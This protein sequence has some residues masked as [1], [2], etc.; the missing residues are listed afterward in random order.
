MFSM[1][2]QRLGFKVGGLYPVSLERPVKWK[3]LQ[4]FP[5]EKRLIFDGLMTGFLTEH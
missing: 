4:A 5:P 3:N 1:R 2:F